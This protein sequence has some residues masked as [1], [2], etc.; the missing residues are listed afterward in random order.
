MTGVFDDDGVSTSPEGLT[1]EVKAYLKRTGM[2]RRS[3][4]RL[5][6]DDIGLVRR[7]EQGGRARPR[8]AYAIRRFMYDYPEGLFER[9]CPDGSL[10]PMRRYMLRYYQK[11]A[12]RLGCTLNEAAYHCGMRP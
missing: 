5:V 7:L 4:G 10:D 2:S 12:A 8:R 1:E 9:G 6:A 3:F 11:L